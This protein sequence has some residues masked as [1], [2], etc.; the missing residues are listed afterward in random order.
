MAGERDDDHLGGDG[1]DDVDAWAEREVD[2]AQRISQRV[3]HHKGISRRRALQ[4]GGGGLAVVLFFGVRA[5]LR[6]NR[7]R[8]RS[9]RDLGD[10]DP[11]MRRLLNDVDDALDLAIVDLRTKLPV[12][13]EEFDW[14]RLESDDGAIH[15]VFHGALANTS[16]APVEAL[17]AVGILFSGDTFMG[18]EEK[19]LVNLPANGTVL[20]N[21]EHPLVVRLVVASTIERFLVAVKSPDETAPTPRGR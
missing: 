5:L 12:K 9:E 20:F 15:M 2:R 16:D 8:G 11:E 17:I 10:F 14:T 1:D 7:R 3:A 6:W 13:V 4:A 18:G 19:I 21:T